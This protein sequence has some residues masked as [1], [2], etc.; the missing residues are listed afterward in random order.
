MNELV[1]IEEQQV[2]RFLGGFRQLIQDALS[3]SLFWTMKEAYQGALVAEKQQSRSQFQ[4]A[5]TNVWRGR[6]PNPIG[7][8][9]YSGAAKRP[10]LGNIG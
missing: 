3:L 2:A 7:Q 1:E 10:Q 4:K 8:P 6:A 9:A 5:C